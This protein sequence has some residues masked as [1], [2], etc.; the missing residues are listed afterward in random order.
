MMEYNIQRAIDSTMEMGSAVPW[1][2]KY[3][4]L[5]EKDTVKNAKTIIGVSG[6]LAAYNANILKDKDK[7]LQYLRRMLA[8]DPTNAAIQ[9]NISVLEKS[10]ANK[11]EPAPKPVPSN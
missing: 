4:E 3:L 9:Q 5:L 10:P 6:Y 8:L 1:A 7:A 2:I 11:P